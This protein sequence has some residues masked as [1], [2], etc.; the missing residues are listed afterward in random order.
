M[1]AC[2]LAKPRGRAFRYK[3][4]PPSPGLEP[5]LRRLWAFRCNRSRG[6]IMLFRF[7]SEVAVK[8]S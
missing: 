1:W 7:T 4:S 8:L 5:G 3:S 2:P 6:K